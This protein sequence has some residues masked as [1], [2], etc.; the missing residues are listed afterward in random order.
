[1]VY[2]EQQD[3]IKVNMKSIV[4]AK[5]R[6]HLLSKR[7]GIKLKDALE[8]IAKDNDFK[9][10]KSY[11]DSLDTFWCDNSSSSYLN[12]WFVSHEEAKAFQLESSGYLLTYKGQYFVASSDYVMHL[13]ID[14]YADIWK[15]I[16]FDV[17]SSD[18]IDKIF[19]YFK[20]SI[21]GINE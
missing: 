3:Y 21:G 6:A 9:T 7:D 1:M 16:K 11:K 14:P 18:S 13:G 5:K 20:G 17:S 19:N 8:C 2:S 15:R 10:W 4:E 12:H